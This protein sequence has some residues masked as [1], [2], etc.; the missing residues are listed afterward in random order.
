MSNEKERSQFIKKQRDRLKKVIQECDSSEELT[1]LF[2]GFMFFLA[3]FKVDEDVVSKSMLGV[4]LQLSLAQMVKSSKED[5][6]ND[7]KDLLS[8][9][10]DMCD[11]LTPD[12]EEEEEEESD[13]VDDGEATT[14]VKEMMGSLINM[15][16]AFTKKME[17]K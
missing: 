12:S 7:L 8:F 2:Y 3:L 9:H 1:S 13:S 10:D 17:S 14:A 4:R 6:I 15:M 16:G 11:K 5:S